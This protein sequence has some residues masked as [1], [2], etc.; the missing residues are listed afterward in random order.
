MATKQQFTE[1]A[2]A[3]SQ[4]TK[5]VRQNPGQ[6]LQES[7]PDVNPTHR[8]KIIKRL[9]QIPLTQRMAYIRAMQGNSPTSAIKAQCC[10][11]V[12]WVRDEVTNCTD[13]GCP[14]YTYRPF[15]DGVIETAIETE[16]LVEQEI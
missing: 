10:E 13:V 4:E 3:K 5:T 11:C 7:L 2:R 1:S 6:L 9:L 16:S 12:G 14:L 15:Q 8:P